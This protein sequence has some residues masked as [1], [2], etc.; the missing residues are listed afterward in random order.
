MIFSKKS[1][2]WGSFYYDEKDDALRVKIKPVATDKSAEW[3]K[4]EFENQTANTAVVDLLW[5]KLSFPFKVEVDLNKTQIESFRNELKTDKGFFWLGW[6]GAAQWCVDHN[7]NLDEALLWADTATNPNV[8][9]D[10]NFTTLSTKSQVLAKLGRTKEAD[11]VMK[12]AMPLATMLQ[13]HQYARTLL[14]QK[15]TKEALEI[16]KF[17][18]D[19]NPNQFTTIFGLARGY[20]GVG[21]YKKALEFA[22]KALPLSDGLNK[23]NVEKSIALLKEGKDIN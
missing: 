2:N 1:N 17:N 16:F 19:K 3:L 8:L 20:S 14:M 5:E 13:V 4:F 10:R 11:E 23:P 15:R 21:D 18:Y 9:G 22:Q 6:Q 7:T 12:E